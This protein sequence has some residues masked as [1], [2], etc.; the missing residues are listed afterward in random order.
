MVWAR[1]E[2][3]EASWNISGTSWKRPRSVLGL[4]WGRPGAVL[5]PSRG[6]LGDVLG[7]LEIF[8]GGLGASGGS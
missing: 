1:L 5:G 4:S 2:G 6:R 8:F 3:L 7:R